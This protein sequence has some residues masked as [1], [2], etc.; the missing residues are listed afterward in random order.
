MSPKLWTVVN[1]VSKCSESLINLLNVLNILNLIKILSLL[2]LL[3]LPT[4]LDVL[5]VLTSKTENSIK[6]EKVPKLPKAECLQETEVFS[7]PNLGKSEANKLASR[8][9]SRP[10]KSAF[11]QPIVL[12]LTKNCGASQLVVILKCQ[13]ISTKV[14]PS[15]AKRP[16]RVTKITRI[17]NVCKITKIAEETKIFVLLVQQL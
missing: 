12:D 1:C 5:A 11:Q 7:H 6:L 14:R 17:R 13:K 4:I 3:K 8:L 9:N 16:V 15:K 10:R 2:N